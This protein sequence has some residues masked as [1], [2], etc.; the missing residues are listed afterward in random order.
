MY[1]STVTGIWETDGTD[2]GTNRILYSTVLSSGADV[3]F[4]FVFN[5]TLFFTNFGPGTAYE[6]W[7]LTPA[8]SVGIDETENVADALK[9]YPNPVA[10]NLQLMVDGSRLNE[11]AQVQIFDLSGKVI[12][13]EIVS[14]NRI[15]VSELANG[16]YVLSLTGSGKA[17]RQ[18]F[19]VQH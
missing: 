8:G 11:P 4:P 6:L 13:N 7:S 5:N 19:V 12:R 2:A 10:N 3:G 14:S 15:D 9:I 1:R 17:Q 18:R 16:F